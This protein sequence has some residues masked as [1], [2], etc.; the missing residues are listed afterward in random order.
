MHPHQFWSPRKFPPPGTHERCFC[1]N[2]VHSTAGSGGW[3]GSQG[4]ATTQLCI[5]RALGRGAG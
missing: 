2:S 3:G 1:P 5:A 4:H